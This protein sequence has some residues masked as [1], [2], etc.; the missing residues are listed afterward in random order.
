MDK[1]KEE[2]IEIA[3]R[4]FSHYGFS[5]TTMNE[6]A[7]DLKITKANL[8]YYYPDKVALIKDVVCY[9]STNLISQE[10]K[11]IEAYNGDL[12]DTL[13]ALLKFRAEHMRKHYMLYINENLDWIRDNAFTE[14]ID[15]I[16]CKDLEVL[17][18]LL[19]KAVDAGNLKMDNIEESSVVLRNIIKGLGL[20]HT[21]K[22]IMCGIPNLENVDHILD[23][24]MKAVKLIFEERIVTNK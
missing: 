18:T 10:E 8:Y 13:F 4:R 3:L 19:N 17:Q 12:L 6:I 16:E 22:D 2:I 7:D 24:Q 11:M 9:I 1:R 5:K 21:V 23:S 14:F 15:E 20:L